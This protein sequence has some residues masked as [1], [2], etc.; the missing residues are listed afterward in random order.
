MAV[1]CSVCMKK[2][3]LFRKAYSFNNILLE[4]YKGLSCSEEC[5]KKKEAKDKKPKSVQD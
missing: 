3:R 1:F 2:I 4:Q 5:V